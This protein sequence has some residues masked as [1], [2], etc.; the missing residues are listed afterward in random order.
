MKELLGSVWLEINLDSVKFNMHSIRNWIGEKIQIM[1][2]VKGNGY[3][4]DA[5]EIANIILNYGATQLAVARIE[6]AI[7]LRKNKIKAPILV[8]GVAL[9]EQFKWYLDYQIMPSLS[10]LNSA[11][12]F[13]KIASSFN[14]K[15]K[16]H[17][18]IETGM[19]RL[20]FKPLEIKEVITELIKL[21]NIEIEGIYTHFSTAD[22]K[23]KGYTVYQF[24]LFKEVMNQIKKNN[25][26]ITYYHTANSGA[27][28][29]LPETWLDMVRP[30]CLIYG[31]YPSGEI[32]R[33]IK[34]L[35]ALS[36][37][38]RISFIKRVEAESFIGYGRT[39]KTKKE[40]VVATLPVGYADGYSRLLSNSGQVLVRG[41]IAPVVGRVCMDQMMIDISNIANASVGDEVVLWGEQMGKY[42][43]VEDIA[44]KL[45][46][47]V[48]EV[49]HLTDKAR[50][51]K[52]FIKEGKPWKVKNILGEY[53]FEEK[54]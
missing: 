41:E 2:V 29:D 45:N 16:V 38:S 20:G 15:I 43:T 28:L 46:T 19:G 23:D 22:E 51:A 1:G 21:S 24:N 8:L 13:N 52:L 3:G 11:Y 30:G 9:D 32:K 14:Q 5:V 50:V 6:E 40:T 39:Y 18:K 37:K 48:D 27:I 47:I 42:I 33:S 36:F 26:K 53:N 4:H 35:P 34:L 25:I 12:K 7:V 10:D 44:K 49:V 31:L 54:K 17:L